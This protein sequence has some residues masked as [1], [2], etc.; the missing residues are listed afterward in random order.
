L[1]RANATATVAKFTC[2]LAI[3]TTLISSGCSGSKKVHAAAQ[4]SAAPTDY[5]Y[6][7]RTL[8][9]QYM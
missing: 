1:M 5:K 7:P 3:L 9:P 2:G 6:I 8:S 4:H